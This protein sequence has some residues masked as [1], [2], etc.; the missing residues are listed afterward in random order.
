MIKYFMKC[1][2]F[3][4]HFDSITRTFFLN[5]VI[6]LQVNKPVKLYLPNSLHNHIIQKH[7][8]KT[9]WLSDRRYIQTVTRQKTQQTSDNNRDTRRTFIILINTT[10]S[11]TLEHVNITKGPPSKINNKLEIICKFTTHKFL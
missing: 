5:I 4:Y 2:F 7:N 11:S 8:S 1:N 10:N 9:V 3:L 6:D